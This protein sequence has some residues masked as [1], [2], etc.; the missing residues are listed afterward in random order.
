MIGGCRSGKSS[1]A[2]DQADRITKK[3][4]YFIATSIPLD[5]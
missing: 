4:K 2:L 3:D 5:P 1:F